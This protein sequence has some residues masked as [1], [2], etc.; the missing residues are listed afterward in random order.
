[1]LRAPKPLI[2]AGLGAALLGGATATIQRRH[3]QRIAA[4]PEHARLRS[5]RTGRELTARSA[6]GT[7]LHAESFGPDDGH[8]HTVVL[9][10]GWTETISFWTYVTEELCARGFRVLAYDLRGHGRSGRAASGDYALARFGEDL[11]AVLAAG[12]PEGER[13][14]IAGHSLGGMSIAAWAEHHDVARRAS[15][16]ALLNTGFGDLIAQSLLVPVPWIARATK[17]IA[18]PGLL[19]SRAPLP[20]I[21]TPLSHAAI[22]YVA[23]DR[24]ASRARVAFYERMLVTAR[25]DVRADIG[26]AMS[27]MEL[28]HALARL[29]VPT[30]V[31]A[32]ANDRLTPPAHARRIANELPEPAGLIELPDTG[33]MSPLERPHEVTDALAGLAARATAGQRISV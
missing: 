13:A 17:R 33:H 7:A 8:R 18:V 26:I 25:P 22:R 11:E 1:M 12:L 3:T 28:H 4:D 15:A 23:F 6:D 20:R 30:L 14:L 10:H 19:G 21:S 9:A 24:R 16:L 2:S 32:G 29:T 5:P 31:I 27:E